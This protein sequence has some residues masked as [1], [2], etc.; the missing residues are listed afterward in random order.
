MVA[1]LGLAQLT[2][3][4]LAA[5]LGVKQ[6]SLYKHIESIADLRRSIAFLSSVERA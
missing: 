6:P 4:G 5:R 2:L 1:E 3:A